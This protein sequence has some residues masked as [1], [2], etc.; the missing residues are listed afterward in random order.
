M[1]P[2]RLRGFL[3][4]RSNPGK[5]FRRWLDRID[6][7]AEFAETALPFTHR[8]SKVRLGREQLLRPRCL[9]GVQRTED[10]FGS[11]NDMVVVQNH[12]PRHS[13]ISS[14]LLRSQVLIVFTGLPSC[15]ASCSRLNPS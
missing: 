3:E 2:L 8:R 7:G 6:H 5:Q 15:C 10:I 4:P 1:Y 9:I 14:K 13:R 11:K 12:A